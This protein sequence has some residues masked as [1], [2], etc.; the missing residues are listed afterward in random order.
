MKYDEV[1]AEPLEK[2]LLYLAYNADVNYLQTLLHKE[3]MA[4]NK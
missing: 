3:A 1:L 2:C 4:K